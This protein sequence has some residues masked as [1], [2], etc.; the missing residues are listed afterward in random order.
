M[1]GKTI[2][3][4][5]EIHSFRGFTVLEFN[6]KH[7]FGKWTF[8]KSLMLCSFFHELYKFE[9]FRHF[10]ELYVLSI[11]PTCSLY[12]GLPAR[13]NIV[14]PCSSWIYFIDS[15][16]TFCHLVGKFPLLSEWKMFD[17]LSWENFQKV[18]FYLVSPF[19]MLRWE[20]DKYCNM[21]LIL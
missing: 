14:S 15:Y 8:G 2:F 11:F 6:T 13:L 20:K 17:D 9:G 3:T 18:I 19:S 7:N 21:I 10:V 5:L 4:A 12:F 16:F 1:C